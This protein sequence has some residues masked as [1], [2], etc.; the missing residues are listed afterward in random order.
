MSIILFPGQ[1]NTGIS[2]LISIVYMIMFLVLVFW[3]ER[4]QMLIRLRDI[5]YALERLRMMRDE[6][7]RFTKEKLKKYNKE[8]INRFIDN[9]LEFVTVPPVDMDPAGVVWKLDHIIKTAENRIRNEIKQI[10]PELDD[11]Q[12]LNI[13]NLFEASYALNYYYKVIRHY[14]I[15]SKKTSSYILII[16]LQAILPQVLMEAE[17]YLG[18]IQAFSS[19][20]PIGDGA[21]ALVA[22]RLMR[23]GEINE[24][25]KDNVYTVKNING[26]KVYFMKAKGPGGA[27]G[28]PGDALMKLS[29][30]ENF[31]TIFMVDAGLKLEGEKTGS[32]AEGVGAII[33]GIGTEK[34]KIEEVATKKHIPL[35]GI[36]V[37]M[38]LKEAITPMTKE[39]LNG[40]EEA[41][42]ILM[43]RII[44]KS[45]ENDTVMVI[46]VGNTIG[47]AQ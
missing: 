21:G 41:C 42:K 34:Y 45:S 47:I 7:V 36:I 28:T 39:V 32:I 6:S 3:G 24:I 12:I 14:Y 22:A 35:Y 40:V 10:I 46:G 26:R 18:A 44:E 43:Q 13:M 31:K 11:S 38:S 30:I 27:V 1:D 20:Q 16:Q 5:E 33:G 8:E 19:G 9:F 25:E 17:A 4:I 37:K 23:G 2:Q 29:E 15:L